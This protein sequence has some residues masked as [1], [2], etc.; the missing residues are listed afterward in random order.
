LFYTS[1]NPK[2]NHNSNNNNKHAYAGQL[3]G[4][5][6]LRTLLV[7]AIPG[8]QGIAVKPKAGDVLFF[9]GVKPDGKTIDPSSM[10]AGCPVI[11]GTKWTATKWIHALEYN[12][13]ILKPKLK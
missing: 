10:H 3:N 4:F 1:K 7:S 5:A 13:G 6:N 9:W 2:S 11:R 8:S 12:S